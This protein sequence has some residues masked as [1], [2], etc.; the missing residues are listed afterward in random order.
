MLMNIISDPVVTADAEIKREHYQT[1]IRSAG[2]ALIADEP[3]SNNGTD[4]GMSPHSL[5]LS[6]LGRYTAFTLRMYID[7]KMWVVDEIAVHLELF[8][9]AA[10]TLINRKIE[11]KGEL[12]QEQHARLLQIA[13]ACPIHKIITGQVEVVTV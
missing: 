7:R 4:T 12:N 13:N 2:H 5:L 10:G 1:T 9:T 3:A 8:K 11:F 6:S